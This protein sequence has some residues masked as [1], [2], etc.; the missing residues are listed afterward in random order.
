MPQKMSA[1][2][3]RGGPGRKTKRAIKV[4]KVMECGVQVA[5]TLKSQGVKL[6]IRVSMVP[7]IMLNLCK[8]GNLT[9]TAVKGAYTCRW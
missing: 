6:V 1:A 8:R 5:R 4:D 3:S 2:V 7:A 9:G